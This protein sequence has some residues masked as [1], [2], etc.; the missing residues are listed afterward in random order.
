MKEKP[1]LRRSLALIFEGAGIALPC[2]PSPAEARQWS[3]GRRQEVCETSFGGALRSAPPEAGEA[4]APVGVGAAPPGAPST[5]SGL[6]GIGR[7]QRHRDRAPLLALRR[8]PHES[9]PWRA[10]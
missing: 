4:S 7:N 8:T 9:V 2:F 10:D 1:T 3:A 6:P 5:D